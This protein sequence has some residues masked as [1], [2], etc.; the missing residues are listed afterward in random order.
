[1]AAVSEARLDERGGREVNSEEVLTW[2]GISW[3][4][5]GATTGEGGTTAG[6]GGTVAGEEGTVA[7]EDGTVAGEEGFVELARGRGEVIT[8]LGFLFGNG[9]AIA[10]GIGG[11]LLCA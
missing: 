10:G 7:G 2:T 5:G 4:G 1:M 9:G 6:K 8:W 11:N 3:T